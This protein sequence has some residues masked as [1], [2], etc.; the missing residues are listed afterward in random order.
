MKMKNIKLITAFAAATAAFA[1]SV[2][3]AT[4]SPVTAY[5]HN[6][7]DNYGGNISDIYNGSGMNGN[8]ATG[9]ALPA[10]ILDWENTATGSYQAEWQADHM[11]DITTSVNNKMGWVIMDLGED[12][13]VGDMYLWNGGQIG[14]N[15][16]KDFNI[17]YSAEGAGATIPATQG[18]TGGNAADDYTFGVA[19]W[20]QFGV[21]ETLG[22]GTGATGSGGGKLADGVYDLGGATARYVALEMLNRHNGNTDPTSGRIGFSEA[23]F[24]VSPVPEPSTTA[25]L[26]LG[27]LALILRRRK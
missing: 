8:P 7:R 13:N 10:N 5:G 4:V 6:N 25:L 24:V 23:G 12:Y 9:G 18:P 19:A 11:L 22:D 21:T 15:A 2:Q 1:L 16:M 20:T 14:T 17:Y 27:G 3:A 26:G